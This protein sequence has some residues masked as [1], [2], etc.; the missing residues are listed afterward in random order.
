MSTPIIGEGGIYVLQRNSDV[1]QGTSTDNYL[2]DI[3]TLSQG[4]SSRASSDVYRSYK[5]SA[6]IEDNRFTRR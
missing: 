3:E 2:T 6:N 1:A 4:F 5:E